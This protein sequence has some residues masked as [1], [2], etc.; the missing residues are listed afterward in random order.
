MKVSLI[1][2]VASNGAI[3]KNNQLL[4][5]LPADMK[6]FKNTTRGHTVIM[7][8][9]NYES[10]PSK[11]RPL[12]ERTNI[13]L[14]RKPHYVADRCLVANSLSEAIRLAEQQN[15]TECFIIGGGEV[16]KEALEKKV[17]TK[18]YITYV[19]TEISD[20]DTFFY[21]SPDATWKKTKDEKV[22][23]DE[24]NQFNMRFCVFEKIG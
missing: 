1:V 6:Y 21:F 18:L 15:E 20:A 22:D 16:Y 17:C 7:G 3:G 4:W 2:A 5:H 12:P 8:R 13:I 24:K 19:E 23:A 11:F 9:K 14:T 10:I